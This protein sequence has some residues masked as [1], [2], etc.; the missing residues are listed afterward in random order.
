IK[1]PVGHELGFRHGS[2][3]T[4][5]SIAYC[6]QIYVASDVPVKALVTFTLNAGAVN[7]RPH[8]ARDE[9]AIL[10]QLGMPLICGANGMYD[11]QWDLLIDWHGC[12]W[13]WLSDG[14]ETTGDGKCIARMEASFSQKAMFIN[15]R[16]QY[17]RKHLGYAYHK[18]WAF[19][20]SQRV[21]AG[22]CSWEAYRRDISMDKIEQIAAFLEKNLKAYGLTY[23]QVDDGYQK[24]PLPANPKGTMAEGWLTCE[25]TKFPGGHDSIVRAIAQKGFA[26]AVWTNA[27][28]TNPAFLEQHPG[29]VI[30]NDGKP[31]QGEWI[32]FLYSCTPECLATQVEPL[33]HKFREIGY[34]Y[35][36]IDAIRHLLFDGLHECVRLGKMTNE[37]AEA[38]FR[39]Y[40][41]ATRKGLGN[42]VYYLASWGEMHEIV[43]V[44]DACR[45]SMDANPTWAGIR[46]QLFESARWFHTQRILF[47][48]DPDHV[49]VRTKL[50][51][52][53]SVLSL[54]SLSGELYMLSDTA[55]AYTPEKLA[56]IR[57]TLPPLMGKTAE[58]G[59]LSLEYPAYTW[60]KLHGFAVQSH[61]TPVEMEDVS[62]ADALDM[63]GD[64]PTMHNH[65]PFSS[66]WAFH[67]QG[68]Q[69]IWCVAARIATMPLAPCRLPLEKLGL[70][71]SRTYLAFDFWRQ[72][73]LGTVKTALDCTALALGECQIVAL[74]R[75]QS[76]PQ[77]IA[78][79]RHVSMDAVSVTAYC[80]AENR[81]TLTLAGVPGTKEQYFVHLPDGTVLQSAQADGASLTCTQAQLLIVSVAFQ[82]DSAK[83]TLCFESAD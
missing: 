7:L 43:G 38:L 75:L 27:N 34:Q 30:L 71:A 74:H 61:E 73:F 17:Y 63:A 64:F 76:V 54:I 69:G 10:G 68:A 80:A 37:N 26:P 59:E 23:L 13:R 5:Q 29:A 3:G 18:P 40:M 6:Q 31:L 16:M 25:E 2:D 55:D 50:A 78:S 57:K 36:K 48:N 1:V 41:E 66:L 44:A 46:M 47:L 82:S 45:I 79:S 32:D 9:Q 60:T 77:L 53:K 58:T 4:L 51:W 8:R 67:L 70:D 11:T 15:L 39:A 49:C 56:V 28:I 83:V 81:L 52:A 19:R 33:F 24:M 22:W 20:P 14:I 62:L 42:D 35:V 12:A 21:V 72:E 65:H